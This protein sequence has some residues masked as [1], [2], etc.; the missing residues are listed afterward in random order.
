MKGNIFTRERVINDL[1]DGEKLDLLSQHGY[2][3]IPAKPE[4]VIF[5]LLNSDFYHLTAPL[6]H[7]T[8]GLDTT[9]LSQLFLSRQSCTSSLPIVIL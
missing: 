5:T 4:Q 2:F 7:A 8:V 1:N 9:S 3:S 6:N